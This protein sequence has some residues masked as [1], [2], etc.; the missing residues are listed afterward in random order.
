MTFFFSGHDAWL[1]TALRVLAKKIAKGGDCC[2]VVCW[3]Y[4]LVQDVRKDVG[5]HAPA[6]A[7]TSFLLCADCNPGKFSVFPDCLARDFIMQYSCE[8]G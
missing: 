1:R 2:Y 3:L 5:L 8:Y 4:F 6:S 7:E